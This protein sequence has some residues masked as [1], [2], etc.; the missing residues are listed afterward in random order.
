MWQALERLA[1]ETFENLRLPGAPGPD[2]RGHG[3]FREGHGLDLRHRHEGD[4]HLHRQG[5]PVPDPATRIYAVGRSGHRRAPAR[6][7]A[8]PHALL[9]H[10]PDV[11][12]RQAPEGALP[13]VPPGRHRGLRRE[14]RGPRRRDHR[15]GRRPAPQARSRTGRR[16]WST[17]SAAAPAGR[18][19]ARPCAK[20]PGS[21]GPSSARTARGRPRRTRSASSTARSRPAGPSPRRSP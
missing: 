12:L 14:G 6:P 19:T 2:L 21:A 17:R 16:P 4:V 13:P 11:P 8:G 18:P 5:R 9:L 15:D 3:A 20:R 10:G 1:R 7:A